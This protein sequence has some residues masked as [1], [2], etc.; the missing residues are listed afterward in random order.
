MP[1]LKCRLTARPFIHGYGPDS[2]LT[3]H[4][5]ISIVQPGRVIFCKRVEVAGE[6]TWSTHPFHNET[7][8]WMGYLA[9]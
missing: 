4:S 6:P 9:A 5:L 3:A 2:S 7:V 1:G 8:E